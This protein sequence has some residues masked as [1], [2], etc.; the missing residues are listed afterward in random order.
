MRAILPSRAI[1]SMDL[2]EPSPSVAAQEREDLRDP[3]VRLLEGRPVRAVIEQHEVP[4]GN[5]V[6]DRDRD[7]ERL[8]PVVAPWISRAGVLMPARSCV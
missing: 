2:V 3:L 5:V 6:Q 7:L 4:I 1:G 8:H